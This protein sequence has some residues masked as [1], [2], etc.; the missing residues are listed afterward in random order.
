MHVTG[1][2]FVENGFQHSDR[3]TKTNTRTIP[4]EFDTLLGIHRNVTT[5]INEQTTHDGS[6][7]QELKEVLLDTFIDDEKA[8][9]FVSKQ[10]NV[11]DWLNSLN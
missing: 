3:Q 1:Q 2:V 8:S 7:A 9:P 10:F 4:D 6:I 11:F 5:S